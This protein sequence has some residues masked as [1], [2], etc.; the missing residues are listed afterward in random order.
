MAD[1]D[2]IKKLGEANDKLNS[3]RDKAYGNKRAKDEIEKLARAVENIKD[4][5]E[6][7]KELTNQ[8]AELE[9]KCKNVEDID[10]IKEEK[11]TMIAE[12][13]K[14]KSDLE[15]INVRL[16]E[17]EKSRL[18]IWNYLGL[19]AA[20][21]KLKNAIDNSRFSVNNIGSQSQSAGNSDNMRGG[22]LYGHTHMSKKMRSM[23][24]DIV[25]QS[26]LAIANKKHKRHKRTNKTNKTRRTNKTHKIHR[27]H[28]TRLSK[29]TRTG[30]GYN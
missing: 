12:N 19:G 16:E 26:S 15:E 7:N 22:Y 24:N 1:N 21:K 6:N 27:A 9:K 14:L 30:S 11:Q 28:R 8:I 5:F 17:F 23:M 20:I 25:T 2:V 4:T 13:A 29:K 18:G 10:K 3:L